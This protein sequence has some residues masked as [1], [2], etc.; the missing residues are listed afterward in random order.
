VTACDV[1]ALAE[2]LARRLVASR[3]TTGRIF[4]TV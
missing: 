1:L 3:A 2:R 4:L